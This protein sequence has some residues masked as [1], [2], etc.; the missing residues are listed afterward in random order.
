MSCLS[1]LLFLSIAIAFHSSDNSFLL[2]SISTTSLTLINSTC[3]IEQL[4]IV[5]GKFPILLGTNHSCIFLS[6]SIINSNS[7]NYLFQCS[8]QVFIT[9]VHLNTLSPHSYAPSLLYHPVESGEDSYLS[10]N[11]SFFARIVLGVNTG[12]FLSSGKASLQYVSLCTFVNITR[13]PNERGWSGSNGVEESYV[14]ECVVDGSIIEWCE[15]AMY[16]SLVSGMTHTTRH[17]H[18][19]NTSFV[20]CFSSQTRFFPSIRTF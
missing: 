6:N 10:V 3:K 12:T 4:I 9:Q 19:V 11:L 2:T 5:S 7:N 13:P 14:E 20:G 15:D 18:C 17:F 8:G 16:G 1:L